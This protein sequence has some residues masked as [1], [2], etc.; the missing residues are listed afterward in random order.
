[1]RCLHQKDQDRLQDGPDFSCEDLATSS[2]EFSNC[3]AAHEAGRA[4]LS[5]ACREVRQ[6]TRRSAL[7]HVGRGRRPMI[8]NVKPMWHKKTCSPTGSE[9]GKSPMSMPGQN[10]WLTTAWEHWGMPSRMQ[11]PT[12]SRVASLIVKVMIYAISNKPLSSSR[13]G[14]INS[15]EYIP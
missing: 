3:W 14:R 9:P 13:S 2:R 12:R 11:P 6:L 1:M 8:S 7:R 15:K 4:K 10:L 5:S